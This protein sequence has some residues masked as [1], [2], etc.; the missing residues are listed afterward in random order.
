MQKKSLRFYFLLSL[1]LFLSLIVFQPFHPVQAGSPSPPIPFDSHIRFERI[2]VEDGLP[3]ATVLAALQDQDGFM[4][5]ATADGLARY[6]GVDFTVF[7]HNDERN[8]LSNNNTFCIV[9]S[10]DGLLWIG[11][12]PGGLNTYDPR[13]GQFNVYLHEPQNENSLPDNS[14]WSLLEDRDG[15]IWV[16]TRNGLSRFERATNT[17]HNYLPDPEN[18]R[19][20][21]GTVVYR[22]YQ[23]K[24]GTIWVGTRNGLQRYDPATDDFTLFI[25]NPDDPTSISHNNVW[26]ML[27]DSQGNFWVGTRGGGLNLMD[28]QKGTFRAYQNDPHNPA[29]LSSN[30]VWFVFEDSQTNLW[31]LTEDAGLNLFDR[32]NQTFRRFR[33]NPS[34]PLSLSNDDLFWM[35]EDRS[36]ALWITSRYGGVNRLSPMK[37]RFG[38]YRNI[39]GDPN[40]LS[41]NQVYSMLAE[42]NGILWVGTFGGGLNR[43]DRNTG[44]VQVFAHDPQN[45]ASISNNKIY[46]IHRDRQGVLWLATSGGGLNRMDPTS[47]AFTAYRFIPETPNVL[48]S[49]FLT[50]I[51]D[52]D[53]GRLW[54][55]TLGFGLNLFNP[56]SGEMEKKYDVDPENPN[57][58]SEGTV[59]DLAVDSQGQVW[60]ATARGGLNRLNPRTDTITHYRAEENNPNSILN[61]TVHALYLD[62]GSDILWAGTAAG[63]SGLNLS[64]GE[65]QN[66]TERDGLPNSTIMGVQPGLPGELWI[67]TGKGI[68]RFNIAAK[69]FTNYDA[70]DGLQGDQFQIASAHRGPDGTLYFGGSAGLTTF[71]PADI[72]SNPY[73]PRVVFTG[74]SVFNH[75]V[76]AGSDLLPQPITYAPKITLNYDQSVFTLHFAALSYQISAKNAYQYK[77]EGFD[78]DWSPPRTVNHTTYTNLSPG[79]YTFMVR[80][81]NHDGV[82]SDTPTTIEI[83]ILT[84]WW[85]TWWFRAGVLLSLMATALGGVKWRIDSIGAINRQL[86]S[87]VNERTQQLHEAQKKLEEVNLELRAQ[88]EEI[89]RLQQKMREQ[90]IRDALTGVYNRHFLTEVLDAEIS[91][92]QR[93]NYMIAFLLIDLDHFKQINDRYGHLTGDYVLKAVAQDIQAHTRLGDIVC[94][95]GGEEFLV[96]MP[97]ITESDTLLRAE[98]LRQSIE[99]LRLEHKGHAIPIT[100]SVGAAFYPLHGNNSDEILSIVDMAMYAAKQEGR[101]RV[102]IINAQDSGT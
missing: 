21:A 47:G 19:A 83:E 68:S 66:Y 14:I 7:R 62:E 18:P 91:R 99:N 50:T 3:N 52:A 95:F 49:N 26:T 37:H 59:Y 5:F 98:E 102:S 58:L 39:P 80:A 73:A 34:D 81:A 4:W 29:S 90:S 35:T 75:P 86:E 2:L 65:W 42:E 41:S 85:G 78:R 8:S 53:N 22:I 16:G 38:L 94:R 40:S 101:N 55:G 48:S 76:Q 79:H 74:F 32:Q 1:S 11:T 97:K 100:I 9:Q 84:P 63:L 20:L 10:R 72:V 44:E 28:R 93:D 43:I 46:Y 12:D 87:R 23:D 77:M 13:S 15:N 67:S 70:R 24:A 96:I 57:S 36:G 61:D 71:H 69:Q 88:L 64:S 89:T 6:D 25:N 92:A 60:I 33:Y 51:E 56:Q 30:R 31:V 17:F 54:I 82:W 27:E 45:P